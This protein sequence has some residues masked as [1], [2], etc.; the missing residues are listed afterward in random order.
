MR[1]SASLRRVRDLAAAA[2]RAAA[3]E[4]RRLEAR[5]GDAHARTSATAAPASTPV[6]GRPCQDVAEARRRTGRSSA[7]VVTSVAHTSRPSASVG[8]S[9]SASARTRPARTPRS[10]SR[11]WTA[12]ASGTRTAN[13][14]RYGPGW[15]RC[16]ADGGERRL[17][18]R[19]PRGARAPPRRAARAGRSSRGRSTRR[20]RA[21]PGSCRCCWPPCRAGCPARARA[22]SSRTRAGRRGR[23][24]C[25]TSRPGI[26]RTSASVE[27]RM[28]EVR[29]AVLRRDAR[30]AGPRRPRCRRRTRRA[31]R[32]RPAMTGSMTATNS[33]PAAW[34]SRADL[35]HR[36]EQAEEV[37]LRGD[38]ARDRPVR[39]RRASARARRGRSCRRP[40]AVGDERDLVELEPAAEVGP[41]RRPVVRMDAA[42][43]TRTRS[44]R[45]A[46]QVIS[47]ASAVAAAPS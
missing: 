26:W 14:L 39:R 46:R 30:A 45:V 25:P 40:V 34:A 36:L 33:A 19:G 24:S 32:G 20:A 1:S 10:S 44:R 35:G 31:G 21:A 3:L 47:A 5:A 6:G 43:L 27:A 9:G 18:L 12:G 29:P 17:E 2:A 11:R 13:S 16:D 8:S 23:W 37:R 42:R 22:S 7:V 41:Q 15:S 28:P 4:Q 38:D